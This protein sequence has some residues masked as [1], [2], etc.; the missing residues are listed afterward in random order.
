MVIISIKNGH[1]L[2]D[3]IGKE[4]I[5]KE[6]K[7]FFLRKYLTIDDIKDIINGYINSKTQRY[8][9]DSILY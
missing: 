7:E 9:Y 6:Y 3:N 2:H 1:N 4:T 8:I 5:I